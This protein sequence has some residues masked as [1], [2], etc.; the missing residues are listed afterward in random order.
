VP[1][2]KPCYSSVDVHAFADHVDPRGVLLV[3]HGPAAALRVEGAA[4]WLGVPVAIVRL[5]GRGWRRLLRRAGID[6]N[7]SLDDG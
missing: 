6:A 7:E 2:A 1:G 3:K 4:L 5:I